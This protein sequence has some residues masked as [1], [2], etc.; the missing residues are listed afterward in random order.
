MWQTN[1]SRGF[2][3]P[4]WDLETEISFSKQV[5]G[6][7]AKF[8]IIQWG[9]LPGVQSVICMKTETDIAPV[10]KARSI[11]KCFVEFGVE[12]HDW[13]AQSPDLNPSNTFGMNW[14]ANCEPGLIAQHQSLTCDVLIRTAYT[15]HHN[16]QFRTIHGQKATISPPANFSTTK[17]DG[18]ENTAPGITSAQPIGLH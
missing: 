1:T 14:N 13:P 8:Q 3:S 7:T 9:F 12:E 11:Q 16:H 4:S 17:V 18:Q 10:H 15:T 5:F 2:F 6:R